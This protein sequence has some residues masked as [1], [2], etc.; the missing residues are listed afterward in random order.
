MD[1]QNTM[2]QL[3]RAKFI[4][5]FGS[6][7]LGIVMIIGRRSVM[8]TLV[9]VSGW[10]IAAGGAVYLLN[11]LFRERKEGY[12]LGMALGPA[13][14]AVIFG[15]VMVYFAETIDDIFPIIIGITL[16]LNGLSNLAATRVSGE[17]RLLVILMSI[18]LMLCGVL[19]VV[20]SLRNPNAATNT[21]SLYSGAVLVVNGLVDLFLLW[22]M[23][24]MLDQ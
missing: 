20:F 21:V 4:P 11:F 6:I 22:R 12:S 16:F 19:L 9:R 3:L 10:L 7:L 23:K 24:E 13:V 2:K 8:D 5:A 15:L 18:L 17:N 14:I 1:L